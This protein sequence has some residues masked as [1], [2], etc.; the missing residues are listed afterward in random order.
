MLEGAAALGVDEERAGSELVD[1]LLVCFDL[2][3]GLGDVSGHPELSESSVGTAEVEL[4]LEAP[5]D[6]V[7]DSGVGHGVGSVGEAVQLREES[8]VAELLAEYVGFGWGDG[9]AESHWRGVDGRVEFGIGTGAQGG[10]LDGFVVGG[11]DGLVRTEERKGRPSG[12][13]HGGG[14]DREGRLRG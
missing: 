9:R 7:R 4:L 14:Y 3:P 8:R 1:G 11:W 6:G 10:G 2:G 12:G 5:G 13:W